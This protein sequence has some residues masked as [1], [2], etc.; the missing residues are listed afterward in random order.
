MFSADI[1]KDDGKKKY[2]TLQTHLD[3]CREMRALA[4]TYKKI[5]QKHPQHILFMETD[6]QSS[7]TTTFPYFARPVKG[8]EA[9]QRIELSYNAFLV[10]GKELRIF[11]NLPCHGKKSNHSLTL[12]LRDLAC[13]CQSH[14][15]LPEVLQ[16]MC[17]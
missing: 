9:F 2:Q 4:N 17:Q 7:R 14:E 16:S 8:T 11:I 15:G 5:S 10:R 12:R 1:Y 13:Y 6:K 3:D